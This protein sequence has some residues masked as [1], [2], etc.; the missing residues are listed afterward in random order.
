[1]AISGAAALALFATSA[2]RSSDRVGPIEV[3]SLSQSVSSWQFGYVEHRL[4]LRN[5]SPDRTHTVEVILPAQSYG[6]SAGGIERL[7]RR[8]VLHPLDAA[9]ITL[10][11]PARAIQGSSRAKIEVQGVTSKT[12]IL[13]S[14]GSSFGDHYHQTRLPAFVSRGVNSDHLQAALTQALPR[15]LAASPA[16]KTASP[17]VSETMAA[18]SAHSKTSRLEISLTRA[19]S[20]IAAWS[21][22]WLAYSCFA[23]VVLT[24]D[25]WRAAPA[26]VREALSR[27][28]ACGGVVVLVGDTNV[29]DTPTHWTQERLDVPGGTVGWTGIG[30]WMS[31]SAKPDAWESDTGVWTVGLFL[32]AAHRW[33]TDFDIGRTH[34]TYPVIDKLTVDAAG[35]FYLLIVF[36]VL[37]GPVL[38]WALARKQKRIWLLWIVPTASMIACAIILAYSLISEGVTATRRADTVIFLDQTRNEG[39]LAG[40]TGYYTPLTPG[41]GFRFSSE[42]AVAP[43]ERRGWRRSG[44][45][46]NWRIDHTRDQ[47]WVSGFAQARVPQVVQVRKPFVALDRLDIQPGPNGGLVAV[48]GLGTDIATLRVRAPDGRWFGCDALAAGRRVELTAAEQP[49]ANALS[50]AAAAAKAT[51]TEGWAAGLTDLHPEKL[52]I[53]P[54]TYTAELAFCPFL[55]RGLDGRMHNRERSVI[56]GRYAEPAR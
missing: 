27:Y 16:T 11:Q 7:A 12:V 17:V 21:P 33:K 45:H 51:R 25:E 55:E 40:L 5:L 44:S 9:E 22:A 6:G 56:V 29:T 47:H 38:L 49:A 30:N 35:F 39:V 24:S 41:Q 18:A 36:A 15:I 19:E 46:P 26:P 10:P 48:N 50:P 4:R 20:E 34:K 23:G 8:V 13:P 37:A 54:G 14:M 52:A 43:F 31:V 28:A 32:A 3:I 42:T 1:M 53:E 2:A